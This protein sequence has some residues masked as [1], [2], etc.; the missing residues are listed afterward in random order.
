MPVGFDLE[1][2]LYQPHG[3]QGFMEGLGGLI[4]HLFADA[5]DFQQLLPSGGFRFF[6]HLPR[7]RGVA[8]GKIA[9][10]PQHDQHGLIEY[11]FIDVFR[12]AQVQLGAQLIHPR[13]KAAQPRFQK[14]GIVHREVGVARVQLALHSEQ[15]SLHI[16]GHLVGNQGVAPG[17]QVV[18]PPEGRDA[19]QVLL[20]R[21][22]DVKH[23]AVPL[24]KRV[25]LVHH[26]VQ[27]IFR[28]YG[29]VTVGGGLVARQQGLVLD[30]D[31]HVLQYVLQHQ[32]PAHHRGLMPVGAISLRAED[33]PLRVDAGLSLQHGFTVSPHAFGQFAKVSVCHRNDPLNDMVIRV[34]EQIIAVAGLRVNIAFYL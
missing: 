25:Q 16:D 28:E 22:R 29:R 26:E 31:R 1:H 10:G 2:H 11:V 17:A 20:G 21:L 33:S 12:D 7:Q 24:F 30:I 4:G 19:P 15:A 14:L 23:V 6:R 18:V 8:P 13:L 27:R 3:L 5:G 32:R 34:N 9:H